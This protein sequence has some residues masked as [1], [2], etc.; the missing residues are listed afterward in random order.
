MLC[1]S[2]F[3]LMI[4]RPPRSTLTDTL[5]PYTTL[6]RSAR[7]QDRFV[8]EIGD[9]AGHADPLAGG[10]ERCRQVHHMLGRLTQD[11]IAVG[12]EIGRGPVV[13]NHSTRPGSG[14]TDLELLDMAARDTPL[15][16]Q[17]QS[18]VGRA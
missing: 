6:F 17:V 3:F 14:G 15:G 12:G 8:G 11:G 1:Y 7:H 5:F 4:R 2:I 16:C 13:P 9:P 10:E 18:T